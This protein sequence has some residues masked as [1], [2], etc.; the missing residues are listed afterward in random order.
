[1]Y[2]EKYTYSFL[3]RFSFILLILL[4]TSSS[5]FAQ[6]EDKEPVLYDNFGIAL[7]IG[8]VM[9]PPGLEFDYSLNKR[10]SVQM[11]ISLN[12]SLGLKYYI[13]DRTKRRFNLYTALIASNLDVSR[14]TDSTGIPYTS[15]GTN[16]Q[17]LYVPLG[18]TYL[19]KRHFQYSLE[20][21]ALMNKNLVIPTIGL[22]IGYNFHI[23]HRSIR[24]TP[25]ASRKNI[26]SGSIAGMTPLIGVTYERLISARFG[27]EAGIGIPSAGLGVKYYFPKV[28][29]S[30]LGMH[31][32]ASHH[33]FVM[34][35]AGGW[36]TY[37]PIGINRM[38]GN[39][40]RWSFDLGP[41]IDWWENIGSKQ[42]WNM[43]M[44]F[45]IG[46]AF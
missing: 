24:Q 9:L 19:G 46:K 30:K 3:G 27:V 44:N 33:I 22:K 6:N 2:Q 42:D 26:I 38:S 28:R 1:M 14:G 12:Q 23:N 20:A 37:F 40:L 17:T 45:R 11:A 32:G 39:G 43:T 15:F 31:L 5:G 35:W 25:K 41:K 4:I 7:S 36:K 18:I 34:P 16:G 21:G 29:E 13:T 8:G 10:L